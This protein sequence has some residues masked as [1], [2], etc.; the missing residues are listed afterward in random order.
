MLY[1][2]NLL[3]KVLYFLTIIVLLFYS[4]ETLALLINRYW[5]NPKEKP[6]EEKNNLYLNRI[7]PVIP[8]AYASFSIYIIIQLI[9]NFYS[10]RFKLIELIDKFSSNSS[11][12]LDSDATVF[13]MATIIYMLIYTAFVMNFAKAFYTFTSLDEGTLNG[14]KISISKKFNFLEIIHRYINCILFIWLEK[15]INSLDSDSSFFDNLLWIGIIGM[16]LYISVLIWTYF[17]IKTPGNQEIMYPRWKL[18]MFLSIFISL[19]FVLFYFIIHIES[20]YIKWIDFFVKAIIIYLITAPIYLII[21]FIYELFKVR[22][23]KFEKYYT[24]QF[25]KNVRNRS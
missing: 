3:P 1:V 8:F 14:D 21:N 18:Q 24:Y 13:F 7:K 25:V 20:G 6:T 10:G 23:Q 12:S 2:Q 9:D 19:T 5:L 4:V 15:K 16:F 11:I 22:N 17:F